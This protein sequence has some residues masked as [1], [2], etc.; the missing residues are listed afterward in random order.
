MTIEVYS[1]DSAE[2]GTVVSPKFIA[3]GFDAG[4]VEVSMS[5]PKKK[6]RTLTETFNAL[7][8]YLW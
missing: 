2:G 8:V 7:I 4:R 1:D 5:E 3:N 6:R